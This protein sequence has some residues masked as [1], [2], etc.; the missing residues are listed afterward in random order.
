MENMMAVAALSVPVLIN[1][2]H[3]LAALFF[4]RPKLL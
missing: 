4:F 2:V 1:A 3:G